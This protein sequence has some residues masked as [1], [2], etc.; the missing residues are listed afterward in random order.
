MV[1]QNSSRAS[2]DDVTDDQWRDKLTDEQ[3]RVLREGGTEPAFTGEYTD[4]DTSGVYCC[5]ACNAELFTS[6]VKYHSGCG[7]PSFA[8]ADSAAVRLLEDRS[9][10]MMRTE[11]RCANCDSHLGHL[12][13]GEGLAPQDL[14]DQRYCI[15]SVALQLRQS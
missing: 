9:G 4:T 13:R 11:V 6:K 8:D 2:V 12:F 7:W 14:P 1:R 15:N 10:G 5:R 3:Y